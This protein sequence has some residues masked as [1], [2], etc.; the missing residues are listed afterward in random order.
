MNVLD[1]IHRDRDR[2][3]DRFVLGTKIC[4]AKGERCIVHRKDKVFWDTI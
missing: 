1:K 4:I 2:D 3:I